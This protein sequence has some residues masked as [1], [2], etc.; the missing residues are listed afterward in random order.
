M[1]ESTRHGTQ[2]SDGKADQ[3]KIR[4][5]TL[6]TPFKP[7]PNALL[8]ILPL[9]EDKQ[10]MVQEHKLQT[11]SPGLPSHNRARQKEAY[12]R[13]EW[14]VSKTQSQPSLGFIFNLMI[15]FGLSGGFSA[16]APPP[17][18]PVP[19]AV[20]APFGGLCDGP[21]PLGA[22]E[23]NGFLP[24]FACMEGSV[25]DALSLG[26]PPTL[27]LPG[28]GR[29][30]LRISRSRGCR[31]V[32]TRDLCGDGL[33]NLGRFVTAVG[34]LSALSRGRFPGLPDEPPVESVRV[35]FRSRAGLGVAAGVPWATMES[36]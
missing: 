12:R 28:A 22:K 24:P 1:N 17:P 9:D 35:F 7:P 5:N 36:E 3:N 14:S 16:P 19:F 18:F 27:M 34:E 6:K 26:N 11:T 15:G 30:V 2:V 4:I 10:A 20:P 8:H 31:R 32:T 25:G 21:L 23:G 13:K 29:V 33:S